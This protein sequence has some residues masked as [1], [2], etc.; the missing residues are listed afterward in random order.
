MRS[1][2]EVGCELEGAW[3]RWVPAAHETANPE[4]FRPKIPPRSVI[5]LA[6]RR[7]CRQSCRPLPMF[8]NS[9]TLEPPCW[10]MY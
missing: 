2:V 4:C 1:C 8:V 3:H 6:W 5:L 9:A 10:R 7:R